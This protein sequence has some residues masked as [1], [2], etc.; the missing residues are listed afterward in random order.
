VAVHHQ[1]HVY[2][3]GSRILT[4]VEAASGRSLWRSREPGDGFPILVGGYLGVVTKAGALHVAAASP[5]G[6]R[7]QA[8]L[9]LFEDVV[10]TPPSFANGHVFARSHGEIARVALRSG[11]AVAAAPAAP[12]IE[13]PR[14]ARL[15]EELRSASDKTAVV[16][17]FMASIEQFPLVEGPDRVTFL[18]R[19]PGSDL[20]LGGDM[21]GA[22]QDRPMTRLEGTDLFYYTT[23]LEPA[24]RVSYVF[25]RDYEPIPDPRNPRQ[26]STTLFDRD[27]EL[28]FSGQ[29]LAMSW[30]ALPGWRAPEH[31]GEVAPDSRGRVETHELESAVLGAK[32]TIDVYLPAG[33]DGGAERYPVLYVHEGKTARE[34]GRLTTALDNLIGRRVRPL[35]AVF[36]HH[37]PF[38][39]PEKY[40]EL[41]GGE[42]VP[43]VDGRYRTIAAPE[44][45]ASFGAGFGGFSAVTWAFG[46]PG[47]VRKVAV[48]SLFMLDSMLKALEPK[49][50]TAEE[51][52]LEFYLEWGRYDLRNPQEAW[53]MVE[54][55][56]R[57]AELLRRRGY[58]PAGGE[59][60]DGTGWP[61]WANRT[62]LVLE[63]LFPLRGGS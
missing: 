10:W 58:A 16:D 17:R 15:A 35:I 3:Y 26:T 61:S 62:D 32:H 20:G 42:V 63:T 4:C 47:A 59:V 13:S 53:N 41:L 11:V 50:R 9:A 14:I 18:Y 28:S 23:R 44:A 31:L 7:E 56:R 8:R 27:L 55:N 49:I 1:G 30:A 46:Q 39:A 25:L 5:E 33:Y 40:P 51:Q 43:F 22:R 36:I 57:F 52:P 24:S 12:P 34:E 45:R 54:T 60:P 38:Q 19:G 6:Y 21:I 48:Q 2:G 37:I 29:A